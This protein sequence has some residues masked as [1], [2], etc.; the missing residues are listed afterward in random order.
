MKY[1]IIGY[2][3]G[4]GF[5]NV[6]KNTKSTL[7]CLGIM[8]ATM[9]IFGVFFAITENINH[10]ITQIESEQGIEVFIK[11]EASEEQVKLLGDQIR[12]VNGVNNTVFKSKEEALNQMK[13]RFKEKQHLLDAVTTLPASYVV[14]LT[15]LN[16]SGQVQEE[17]SKLD[18]VKNIQS[19]DDTVKKLIDIA[20]GIRIFSAVILILLVMISVFIIS[21]TIK[22]TV[23][24]RR[25]EISIMKYVGATNGFI[26]WPFMVEG[27]IIGLLAGIISM[28]IIGGLYNT[29]SERVLQPSFEE[30]IKVSLLGFSEMF[31]LLIIVFLIMGA[32]IGI[33]GS[34]IS[35]KKYLN[36]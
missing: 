29:L 36:V 9:L 19:S 32:G 30:I 28:L 11:N 7:A 3:I 20:N 23:H 14:T 24:A 35:M 34:S 31:S 6:F 21:N 17:I 10:M 4:E 1:N 5:R 12:D 27:V 13:A 15:D 25:K 16:L 2:L 18:S 33:I 26:R 8:C 22:L